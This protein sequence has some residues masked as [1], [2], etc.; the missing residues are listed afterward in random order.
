M[1][2]NLEIAD[3]LKRVR[4]YVEHATDGMSGGPQRPPYEDRRAPGVTFYFGAQHARAAAASA[5]HPAGP[6]SPDALAP[7]EAIG[8]LARVSGAQRAQQLRRLLAAPGIAPPLSLD[9][10]ITLL[11]DIPADGGRRSGAL[12]DLLR[13][14]DLPLRTPAAEQ[15]IDGLAGTSRYTA[16]LY[17][18]GCLARPIEDADAARLVEGIDAVQARS[19]ISRLARPHREMCGRGDRDR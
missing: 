18:S 15:L 5:E 14:L 6:V 10:A 13:L 12:G 17:M 1:D 7:R 11:G 19:I 3:L 2:P 16:L 8:Q 9:E 4:T